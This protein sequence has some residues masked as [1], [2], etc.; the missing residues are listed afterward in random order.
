MAYRIHF[1]IS[2][3]GEGGAQMMLLK[4]LSRLDRGVFRPKVIALTGHGEV[5]A[6]M[7]GRFQDI[8]VPVNLL[9]M[10]PGV[11]SP[12]GLFDLGRLFHRE[13]PHLVQTWM[14]HADLIGGAAAKLAGNIPVIWNIRHSNLDPRSDK[15][16]TILTARICA[17]LSRVIPRKIICC[18]ERARQVHQTLGYAAAKMVV[19]PNGF[20]L[21]AFKPDPLAHQTVC[22]ELGIADD[23]VL[24]GL[25]ARFH[26]QKDHATFIEAARAIKDDVR[27]D[28]V[29]FILCGDGID[30]RNDGLKDLIDSHGLND[31]F[32]LLGHRADIPRLTAA[33]NLA[34]SSSSSGEG[35]PN[36]I[37]EAMACG[38]P[39][40][41]T[42]VG[43]SALIVGNAGAVVPP[44]DPAALAA[45]WK[46]LLSFDGQQKQTLSRCCRDRMIERFSL[47]AIVE[48]YEHLFYE[49]IETGRRA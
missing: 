36:T 42:N 24:I 8:D 12:K 20:D 47:P 1:V 16:T 26:P 27:F 13:A 22:N 3:L 32:S 21:D 28:R 30:E 29:H 44:G 31:S 7:V 33:L 10:R 43:D 46:K 4:L 2:G 6:E 35:F 5:T 34:S 9:G 49:T 17:A 48:R 15:K 14:Y 18:A 11:P 40:V 37:G 25:F 41:V 39:C 23:S 38:I 45:A 19:I